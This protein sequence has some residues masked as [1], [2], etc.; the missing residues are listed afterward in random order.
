[1]K[2]R[3]LSWALTRALLP[4]IALLWVIT[5]AGVGWYMQDRKSVV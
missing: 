1:M 4:W 2:A 3:S 5:S